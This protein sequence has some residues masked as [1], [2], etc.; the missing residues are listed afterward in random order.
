MNLV[1]LVGSSCVAWTTFEIARLLVPLWI[2]TSNRPRAWN[3][4]GDEIPI[5]VVDNAAPSTVR[6]GRSRFGSHSCR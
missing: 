4:N 1:F 6:C 3:S 5:E 2:R